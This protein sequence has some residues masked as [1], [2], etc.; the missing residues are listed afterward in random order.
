M[1][2]TLRFGLFFITALTSDWTMGV[3]QPWSTL[4]AALPVVASAVGS[5]ARRTSVRK[6]TAITR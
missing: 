2:D 6:S 1:R 5:I 3:D 4:P